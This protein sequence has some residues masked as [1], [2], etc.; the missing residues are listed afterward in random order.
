MTMLFLSSILLVWIWFASI[1]E[2]F[3]MYIHQ[4]YQTWLSL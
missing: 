1:F 3:C 2:D 4:V